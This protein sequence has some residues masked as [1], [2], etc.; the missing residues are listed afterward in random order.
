MYMCMIGNPTH[1]MLEYII[2]CLKAERAYSVYVMCMLCDMHKWRQH[3]GKGVRFQ[4]KWFRFGPREGF[5]FPR[6]YLL[7]HFFFFFF[8]LSLSTFDAES[9]QLIGRKLHFSLFRLLGCTKPHTMYNQTKAYS[10]RTVPTFM[11]LWKFWPWDEIESV[12]APPWIAV[13]VKKFKVE[14]G[15]IFD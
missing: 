15:V 13:K 12:K 14:W 4:F 9:Y 2:C 3:N 6:F 10:L 11:S 7:L 5:F 1:C 8:S